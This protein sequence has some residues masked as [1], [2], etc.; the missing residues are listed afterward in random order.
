MSKPDLTREQLEALH[1]VLRRAAERAERRKRLAG[2]DQPDPHSEAL[3]REVAA[4]GR[5]LAGMR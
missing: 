1:A 3:A 5:E 4:L 2:G